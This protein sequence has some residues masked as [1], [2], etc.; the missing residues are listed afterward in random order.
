M[1]LSDAQR[2]SARRIDHHLDKLEL[3]S[4]SLFLPAMPLPY[5]TLGEGQHSYFQGK[6]AAKP[7]F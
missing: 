3:P 2:G 5:P 6:L 7:L 1:E 4:V